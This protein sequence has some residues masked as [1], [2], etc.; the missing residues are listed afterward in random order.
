M[1]R[2]IIKAKKAV[3][4]HQHG[5]F[6]ASLGEGFDFVELIEYDYLS[7]AKKIDWMAYAKTGQAYMKLYQEEHMRNIT[8]IPL[9]SGT[10]Y[11]GFFRLKWEMLLESLALIGFSA[12]ASKDNL[13]LISE[14]SHILKISNEYEL[15]NAITSIAHTPII[16]KTFSYN[17]DELFYR[18]TQKHLI[19][20]VGDFLD[21]FS[22]KLLPTK[23]E[24][25]AIAFASRAKHFFKETIV[26]D[27][28]S[29]NE[30]SVK[31]TPKSIDNYSKK[32]D[33]LQQ[34]HLIQLKKAGCDTLTIYEDEDIFTKLQLF[35]GSR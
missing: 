8:I 16:G 25:V 31:L 26:K 34:E 1:K 9:M 4:A 19:I 11:F 21:P 13:S 10:L 12:L 7:D 2:L 22:L 32:I 33:T 20:L 23:H 5:I 17:L 30:R 15:E 28:Q 18:L 3:Y 29:L 14:K 24:V 27:T 6:S 35:F